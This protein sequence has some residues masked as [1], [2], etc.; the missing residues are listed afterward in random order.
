MVD[1][2]LGGIQI[3]HRD[4]PLDP[5][6]EHAARFATAS[7]RTGDEQA[8]RQIAQGRHKRDNGQDPSTARMTQIVVG[9]LP[10]R[11]IEPA[12]GRPAEPDGI[13]LRCR[14]ALDH[15]LSSWLRW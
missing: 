1:Q 2:R 3:A 9:I 15:E 11:P 4:Q 10:E 13:Q 8:P 5:R 6:R 7:G 14:Q 12:L